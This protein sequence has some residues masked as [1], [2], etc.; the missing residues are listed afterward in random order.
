MLEEEK[1]RSPWHVLRGV[2][3]KVLVEYRRYAFNLA[4]SAI[5]FTLL[6]GVILGGMRGLAAA[7]GITLGPSLEGMV[8][9]LLIWTLAVL[10]Y[11]SWAYGLVFEAQTGTLEQLYLSPWGFRWVALGRLLGDLT[12]PLIF[13]C[14]PITFGVLFTG[15]A[16]RVDLFTLVPL[17]MLTILQ[18]W[19]L[20]LA[21]GGLALLYKRIEA[22][23]QIMQ[24][25]IAGLIG[26]AAVPGNWL[27][28]ALPFVLS[29]RAAHQSLVH[30][31][32]LWR[33]PSAPALLGV[34]ALWLLA[35]SW[36]YRHCE[37]TAMRRGL[38]GHY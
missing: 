7:E 26:L 5:T 6:F 11:Q 28:G 17:A 3:W 4:S 27:L 13:A 15:R 8:V 35:G 9:G 25:L 36:A 18:A 12:F 16:F 24:F 22:S 23:F 33:Q 20:G 19:S 10:S 30:G 2:I 21:L 34:T 38:L 29:T 31:V 32:P 1:D 14:L 37:R